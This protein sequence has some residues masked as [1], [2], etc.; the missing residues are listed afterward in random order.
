MIDLETMG[1]SPGCVVTHV[2]IVTFNPPN[3]NPI[4]IMHLHL[5]MTEQL[6][7]GLKVDSSTIKWWMGQE[8]KA[9]NIFKMDSFQVDDLYQCIK[10]TVDENTFVWSHATFDIPIINH[11]LQTFGF[12]SPFNYRKCMDIRTAQELYKIR[13]NE[14]AYAPKEGVAH[15]AVDDCKSQINLICKI[16]GDLRK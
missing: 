4:D 3:P 16:I 5:S 14:D 8:D 2:A 6:K 1:R 11:L 9:R 13:F 12:K 10:A 15:N 7:A